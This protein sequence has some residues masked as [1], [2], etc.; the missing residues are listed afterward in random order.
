MTQ[1]NLSQN[2]NSLTDAD[3]RLVVAKE[4]GMRERLGLGVQ[5]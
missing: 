2:R 4:H 3:N 5:G 1:M